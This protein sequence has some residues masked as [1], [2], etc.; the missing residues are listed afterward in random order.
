[1]EEIFKPIPNFSNYEVSNLGRVFALPVKKF[2]YRARCGFYITKRKEKPQWKEKLGY[3]QTSMTN[4]NGERK[5]MKV[6]RLVAMAFIPNPENKKQVNH[7]DGIKHHNLLENLEWATNQENQIHAF[8]IG[9]QKV[10]NGE[11][12][13]HILK[14][15]QVISIKNRIKKGDKIM[16]IHKDYSNVH[17][18][19][20]RSIQRGKTWRHIIV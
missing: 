8:K 18:D 3:M 12:T 10:R 15:F 1:M 6:H 19:T 11:Q 2:Q 5:K 20:L 9:L 7:I 17:I 16:D 14:D 13:S 4:D